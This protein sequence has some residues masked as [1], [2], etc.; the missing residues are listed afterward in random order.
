MELKCCICGK[1]FLGYG[2]NAEPI[3]K[4]VCCDKCNTRFVIASRI[5]KAKNVSYEIIKT[6]KQH[7][8]IEQQLLNKGFKLVKTFPYN[9]VYENVE[10]EEN[11]VL[12]IL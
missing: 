12:C 11:V 1:E 4:G 5:I 6:A 7:N 10:N 2:N 9:A 3:R 8:E